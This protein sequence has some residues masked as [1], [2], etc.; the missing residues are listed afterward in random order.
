MPALESEAKARTKAR[1]DEVFRSYTAL[2]EERK[3]PRKKK[4][5][6]EEH[7]VLETFKNQLDL[8]KENA[9]ETIIHNTYNEEEE[10]P[11]FTK[12]KLRDRIPAT[13]KLSNV[14]TDEYKQARTDK[15][16]KKST[17]TEWIATQETNCD[18]PKLDQQAETRSVAISNEKLLK[19]GKKKEK[20]LT[21]E[22]QNPT[23]F[24]D[25]D[26]L[27]E[28]Y[29]LQV[30]QEESNEIKE[31]IK[32]KLRAQI[33]EMT[34]NNDNGAI[35][36]NNEIGVKKKR[37]KKLVSTSE[38]DTRVVSLSETQDRP[39]ELI[40]QSQS[41]SPILGA[42]KEYQEYDNQD[43]DFA[44]AKGKKAKSKT[45]TV[46]DGDSTNAV[47]EGRSEEKSSSKR[48]YDDSLVLGV[49]IHKADKLKTD[50]MVSRPIVKVHIFD[51]KT[52]DYIKKENG[53]D[54]VSSFHQHVKN[55]CIHPLMTQAYDFRR[56]KSPVPEWDEQI[57][58]N[59][60]FN[61]FLQEN[62]DHPKVILFFEILDVVNEDPGRSNPELQAQEKGF[63]KIAWAFLKLVGA[64]EVLNVDTKLRLQLYYPPSR[65]RI[66]TNTQ[67]YDW[68]LKHPR[69]R[70]PSTLYVTVK[71]LKLPDNMDP[72]SPTT[73]SFRQELG[74]SILHTEVQNEMA[75]KSNESGE[76]KQKE[77]FRWTRLPGQACHIPNRHLLSLRAGHMGCF[78][79]CFSND[80]RT[81]AA[82]CADRDGYP[83][84]LYEIPSGQYLGELHGHLN[85]VYDLC[86]SSND[87]NL[88]TASSDCTVRLWRIG[89]EATSAL[90]VLPHPSF[91]YTARFHPKSDHLV[92]TGCYD[93]MI[94][95][96]NVRVKETNG[97]LLQ[98]F[99]GHKSFINTLCFDAEGLQMYSGDSSGLI[100]VWNTLISGSSRHN[101]VEH[102]S[103][104]KEIREADMKGIPVNHL[105][106]H[107][108][109]RRLLIHSKDS[110][111]RIMDLRI[112][113]A[114]KY[115]GAT[116]YREKIHSTFTPCG[117]FVF[118]G[119]EDGIAYVWNSE[120]G[121][122]VAKFSELSYTAPVRDVAFHP[123]EHM[124]A[125]CA[126]GQSQPILVY[127]YDYRVAQLDAEAVQSTMHLYGPSTSE[128]SILPDSSSST[129]RFFNAA[130]SSMRMLK[131]KQKLDS[132]LN[133]SNHLLPS[134]SLLSPHSKLRL[135]GTQSSHLI[136]QPI[137][138]N[139]FG[140]FSP[141]GQTLS[142]TPSIKL[143][144]SN[145]D[146]KVSSLKIEADGVLP[147]QEIVVALYD[148]TAH[149]SDELTI[150][151]SDIIHVLYK[152]N[153]NWWFGRLTNGQ[154]GYFPANYVATESQHEEVTS[155][156]LKSECSAPVYKENNEARESPKSLRGM[157]AV[158]SK[159]KDLKFMSK[160]DTDA[161]SPVTHE[162][163][164]KILQAAG[165]YPNTSTD[166][167][168]SKLAAAALNESILLSSQET[169]IKPKKKKS[170]KHISS[171]GKTNIAFEPDI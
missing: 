31:K 47:E 42:A 128:I 116:N 67:I 64:N 90:K 114:Q 44:K 56:L 140:G 70:Y 59:E 7:I 12:N 155:L 24:D 152:D 161:D 75:L 65:A 117:T 29:Q 25:E 71:G 167:E 28:T 46:L 168:P 32:K 125:F 18:N 63:R 137:G 77:P 102:W 170:L 69:S 103:I 92:I 145:S 16:K 40:L 135:P 73:M 146:A 20:G 171:A 78:S 74:S 26:Q 52:G 96:W 113:A 136:T 139:S 105:Q 6:Q 165:S 142:R 82:A 151:R 66:A 104:V 2:T 11:R 5:P 72:S 120:T 86:W 17:V 129:D 119:S 110:T 55:D 58:F 138:T 10:S 157:S 166:L 121:D 37:K 41:E 36:L 1:F 87:Q 94:R 164:Q 147:V 97:Q 61:Y 48:V 85:V 148:Y 144:M 100:I 149:R 34:T 30:S 79:I 109:G 14:N 127:I 141:V 89:N 163:K 160:H 91:V 84:Y 154:Q 123:H 143:L 49:Y 68:W 111:V 98:E 45:K 43:E 8:S 51:Q 39:S 27:I 156:N 33:S 76:E 60:R 126:F 22:D 169:Y 115:I 35:P 21:R 101:P 23:D 57:I 133:G 9:K 38:T 13:E 132:V 122:K 118:A 62:E 131:V 150:H 88:L 134:P 53:C 124:V 19:R 106:V 95:V 3:I 158:P 130:R 159:S 153:D 15:K 83:V 107:P 99:D 108:N 4:I 54:T 93:A 162:R 81:L 80:G 50:L 112:L